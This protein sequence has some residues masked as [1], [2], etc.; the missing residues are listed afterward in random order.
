MLFGVVNKSYGAKYWVH[1]FVLLTVF[2]SC[3][4]R[5][6]EIKSTSFDEIFALT[7]S[8]A[9]KIYFGD[10]LPGYIKEI[11][12]DGFSIQFIFKNEIYYRVIENGSKSS[13][14]YEF[15]LD[16]TQGYFFNGNI[17]LRLFADSTHNLKYLV[18][19]ETSME[20]ERYGVDVIQDE[21]VIKR[22]SLVWR[23]EKFPNIISP[24]NYPFE[25][26]D[27]V[28]SESGDDLIIT[29]DNSDDRINYFNLYRVTIDSMFLGSK[30][31]DQ[32]FNENA[33]WLWNDI[34]LSS[35]RVLKYSFK[36]LLPD[37]NTLSAVTIDFSNREYLSKDSFKLKELIYFSSDTLIINLKKYKREINLEI[38]HRSQY[39]FCYSDSLNK[40]ILVA[41]HNI[42]NEYETGLG[43]ELC[44]NIRTDFLVDGNFLKQFIQNGTFDDEVSENFIR[45]Y[46]FNTIYDL[47]QAGNY[48]C[49]E[50]SLTYEEQSHFIST[51]PITDNNRAKYLF[52]ADYLKSSVIKDQTTILG[53]PDYQVANLNFS[54]EIY[55]S[56]LS[57]DPKNS[58]CLLSLGDINWR[59]YIEEYKQSSANA[60]P[61]KSFAKNY[62]NKLIKLEKNL[63][64]DE[65]PDRVFERLNI[66]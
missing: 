21:K 9:N 62:Y 54:M 64:T 65:I 4:G 47:F 30:I 41:G 55:K 59:L 45:E 17:P 7:E 48:G 39:K 63:L 11:S 31:F 24:G 6:N 28:L 27:F 1:M 40:I 3:S 14:W 10:S 33:H 57:L 36:Y 66:K 34:T 32:A 16:N 25:F 15:G 43:E 13:R 2:W 51:H 26:K 46:S 42:Y 38:T 35:N 52:I 53:L 61:L 37:E 23:E 29:S 8:G 50:K 22:Y 19:P 5:K 44:D 18:Y 56:I 49:I 60:P 12:F 20:L 58:E